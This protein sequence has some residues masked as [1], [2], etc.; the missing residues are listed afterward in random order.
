MLVKVV[1]QPH[2]PEL[3]LTTCHWVLFP[4][5]KISEHQ[6]IVILNVITY[7]ILNAIL[8]AT[9]IVSINAILILLLS[10]TTNISSSNIIPLK[11]TIMIMPLI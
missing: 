3:K 8:N 10:T 4:Y 7:I 6:Q 9:N 1:N 5:Q 2:L 11:E